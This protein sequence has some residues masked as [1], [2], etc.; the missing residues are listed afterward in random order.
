MRF[1]DTTY[2][3]SGLPTFIT[4]IDL[5]TGNLSNKT[6]FETFIGDKEVAWMEAYFGYELAKII[7][8]AYDASIAVSPTPLPT[9][10]A[11]IITGAEFTDSQGNLQKWKGL[12]RADKVSPIA[13]YVYFL[14]R[15]Q[16]VT[17]TNQQGE[18]LNAIENST[19]EGPVNKQAQ[20]WN[21]AIEQNHI[22]YEFMT[23]NIANYSEWR[24]NWSKAQRNLLTKVTAL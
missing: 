4:N 16:N 14:W 5:S 9:K 2:F 19:L 7:I 17:N 3:G 13:G 15:R 11:D 24:N 18:V 23:V 8:A 21:D 10:Y 20:N 12:T 1:I 6:A 22:L